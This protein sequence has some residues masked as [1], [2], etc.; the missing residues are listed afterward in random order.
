V[1]VLLA[2]IAVVLV[3][4]AAAPGRNA[5]NC[6]QTS[7]AMK[8]LPD[9]GKGTYHGYHGGLYANGKN[10]PPKAYA[11]TGLARARAVKPIDGKIVLLSIGMSNTTQEFSAFKRVADIDPRKNPAL[12]IVDGAQGGQDAEIIKD[13][14]ARFWN[15]VATRLSLAGA[16]AAQVQAVWLKEAIARE[17]NSFPSD[18]KRLKTDLAGIVGI[19]RAKFPNLK[20]VYLSSRTYAGYASTALNPEPVAYDSGFAV[21]WLILDR[22]AGKLTGPWLAWGPYLWTNGEQGRKD[23]LVWTC[24]DTRPSDGTH[25]SAS[26]QQKVAQLLLKFFTTDVTAKPWFVRAAG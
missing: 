17:S 6:G 13:P 4:P 20:V 7:V 22:I 14:N 5:A 9:L 16:S 18:A 26:G 11:K 8:P 3:L 10:A 19:L 24:A 12:T 21:K 2:A 1:K 25:P 23:G 15:I